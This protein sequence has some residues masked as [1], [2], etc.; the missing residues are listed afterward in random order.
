MATQAPPRAARYTAA[1]YFARDETAERCELIGGKYVMSPGPSFRHQDVVTE[2]ATE[3]RLW[4]RRR[5]GKAIVAPADLELPNGDVV[6][7]DVL[8]YC[9][10]RVPPLSD[11]HLEA[12]P[13]LVVEVLS[14]S[15]RRHDLRVK[16][17]LYARS[18]IAHYW[19][20]DPDEHTL[21]AFELRG[22]RYVVAAELEGDAALEPEAF[23]GLR[24]TLGDLWPPA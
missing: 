14:P 6:Q 12:P 7:P 8:L 15:T 22:A 19:V 18:G 4:A 16:R 5:G 24:I 9:A 20:V 17:E 3:L 21:T 13:D 23:P 10:G 1:D 2:L 11:P